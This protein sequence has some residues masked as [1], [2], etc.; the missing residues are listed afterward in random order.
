M[1]IHI[2]NLLD[3]YVSWL[4]EQIYA[5]DIGAC[6]EV[7]TPFIDRH[8]DLLQL[9]VKELSGNIEI[10]D[11]GY[12]IRDLA[13]SGCDLDTEKRQEI[14]KTTLAGFGVRCEQDVLRVIADETDFAI[15]QNNLIQAMLSVNDMFMLAA[16]NVQNIFLEDI[17]L[18]LNDINATFTTNKK[19]TGRT[20]YE[21]VFDFHMPAKSGTPSRYIQALNQPRRDLAES[22]V[23]KWLDIHNAPPDVETAYAVLNDQD[24]KPSSDIVRALSSYGIQPILWSEREW[25]QQY[26]L[27]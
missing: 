1:S 11:A 27:N 3:T 22:L 20:G 19:V 23:F 2:D 9:Y 6:Y 21:H 15:K 18:W 8:N 14:F 26:L 5:S 10:S 25:F 17:E 16:P 4:R 7:T 12:I 13:M 24:K